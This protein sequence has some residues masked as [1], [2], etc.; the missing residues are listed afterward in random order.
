MTEQLAQSRAQLIKGYV[1]DAWLEISYPTM[2]PLASYI[3]DLA[4]RIE[5]LQQ[6]VT[7]QKPP[8]VFWLAGFF[9]TQSF[10]TAILQNYA[11]KY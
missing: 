1:P 8:T 9:F 4:L 10:L 7:E 2:K 6:W 3:R 11:R 5:T